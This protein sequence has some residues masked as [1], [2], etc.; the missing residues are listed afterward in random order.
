MLPE[1]PRFLIVLY[2]LLES[3]PTDIISWNLDGTSFIVYHPEAF[4]LTVLP[5]YFNHRKLASFHRQLNYFGFRKLPKSRAPLPTFTHPNFHRGSPEKLCWIQRRR[6]SPRCFSPA[7]WQIDK[8][9]QLDD[10]LII[11]TPLRVT[12][13]DTQYPVVEASLNESECDMVL[14]LL[15]DT[16]SHASFTVDYVPIV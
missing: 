5:K 10:A 14:S 11:A 12:L 9:L 2:E 7:N 13:P 3:E 6:S 4:E 16:E 15:L 8:P 1:T